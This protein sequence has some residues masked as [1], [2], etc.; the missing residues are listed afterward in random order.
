M[1]FPPR[2]KEDLERVFF[3]LVPA[4]Y[5]VPLTDENEGEGFDAIAQAGAQLARASEAVTVTTQAYYLRPHSTQLSS[6]AGRAVKAEGVVLVS[7]TGSAIGAVELAAGTVFVAR[8][9]TP[10]GAIVDGES[11]ELTADVTIPSGSP[12]P[13]NASLRALRVGYQGNQ[14]PGRVTAFANVGTASVLHTASVGN[15]LTDLGTPD[16]FNEQQIGQFLRFASGPNAGTFPRRVLTVSR[17][18]SP[19]DPNTVTV[20]GPALIAGAGLAELLEYADLGLVVTQPSSIL[21]GRH[22]WLDAIAS[23][24]GTSRAEGELDGSLRARLS[25]LADVVSPGAILRIL[26]RALTPLGIP[27]T[28]SEVGD[29]HSLRG[30]VWDHDPFDYGSIEDGAVFLERDTRFF[31]VRVGLGNGGEFGAPYDSPFPS[32][33]WDW[34]FFDGYPV[35]YFAA[36]GALYKAIE[37]ARAAGIGWLL[38]LDPDL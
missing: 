2:S 3:S 15:Q 32:N 1:P 35:D 7:R 19:G 22:G 20:D 30:F 8:Y 26:A 4:D 16:V 21:G 28:F 29:P 36:L 31:V 25:A 5:S 12:G 27:Y 18:T 37:A 24:R 23:D 11:Y 6:P 34:M 13:V 38:I 17:G 10:N 14:P 9:R 33:A